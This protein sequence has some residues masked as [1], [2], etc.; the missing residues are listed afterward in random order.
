MSTDAP[1]SPQDYALIN[2]VWATLLGAVVA[3][4]R[5]E[6]PPARE[7]PLFGLA[8]FSL[9]KTLSK[10]K[11]GTWVRTPVVDE[12]DPERPPKGR[13]LRYA[14]GELMTCTRCLGTWSALGLVGLRAA[15]PREAR[16][17]AGVLATSAINDF[18]QAGFSW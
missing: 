6:G 3:A 9:T 10:E 2:V 11:V 7:L 14:A 12:S 8:S 17:V 4:T 13:G 1:T 16:L 5:G 15:R 18:L